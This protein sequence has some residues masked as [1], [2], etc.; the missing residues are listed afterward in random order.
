MYFIVETKGNIDLADLNKSIH[1]S[2][3]DK[4]KC[5]KKTLQSFGYGCRI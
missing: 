5:G 4:I 1:S 3:Q 2:A